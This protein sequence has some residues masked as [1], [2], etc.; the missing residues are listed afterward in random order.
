MKAYLSLM[1]VLLLAIL[2]VPHAHA[3]STTKVDISNNG[4]G[5]NNSVRIHNSTGSNT[6]N[7]Q[8]VNSGTS[9][10]TTRIEINGKVY[11]DETTGGNTATDIEVKQQG[12][13]EPTIIYNKSKPA[14][15][16]E[17]AIKKDVKEAKDE[18][19]KKVEDQEAKAEE[20]VKKAIERRTIKQETLLT[21]MEALFTKLRDLFS[22]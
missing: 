14:V 11:V 12:N 15:K 3:A 21:R 18:I 13:A 22:K 4:E 7:G 8:S 20:T 2:A 5:S 1:P 6:I 17:E 9:Q 16:S 19:K 10:S